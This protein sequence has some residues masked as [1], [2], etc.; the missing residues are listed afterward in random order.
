MTLNLAFNRPVY[1][2]ITRDLDMFSSLGLFQRLPCPQLGHCDHP[3][4]I[5]SHSS[6][7]IKSH[8]VVAVP[9]EPTP[10]PNRV[11]QVVPPNIPAKRSAFSLSSTSRANLSTTSEPPKKIQRVGTLQKTRAVPSVSAQGSVRHS[12]LARAT[13]RANA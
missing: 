12:I 3:N 13:S 7:T 11:Q 9:A 5:F 4:C 10:H 2:C 8:Y 1:Y 6:E